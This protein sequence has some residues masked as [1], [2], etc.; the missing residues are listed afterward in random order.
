MTSH[1]VSIDSME[2]MPYIIRCSGGFLNFYLFKIHENW[3]TS[4]LKLSPFSTLHL[5]TNI[6]DRKDPMM[7]S[8]QHILIKC[9][10]SIFV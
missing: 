3:M 1:S 2:S 9:E 10:N 4:F 7:S 6:R 5:Q 8:C